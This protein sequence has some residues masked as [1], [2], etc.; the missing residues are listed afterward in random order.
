MSAGASW[1]ISEGKGVAEEPHVIAADAVITL[2]KAF[3]QVLREAGVVV[4]GER[5]A[6]AGELADIRRQF[7]ELRVERQRGALLPGLV[8]A[9]THL[10]LSDRSAEGLKAASFPQWVAKLMAGG[11]RAEQLE[12]AVRAAVRHG[13]AESLRAGVTTIGEI[14]RQAACTRDELAALGRP[15]GRGVPRVVSFGEVLGLGKMRARAAGLIEAAAA[16]VNQMTGDGLPA[17]RR[18]ISPHAPYTVEGPVLRACL[19]AAIVKGLAMTMHLAEVADEAAFLE[20]L[21]G[22]LGREW[23][24]M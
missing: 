14:S 18:G 5:I 11:P 16:G 12:G 13:A 6:G 20:E 21:S 8:N 17:I 10:E 22:S 7:G 9:H 24:V 23:T 4:A 2:D 1:G 15:G 3:P 19:R